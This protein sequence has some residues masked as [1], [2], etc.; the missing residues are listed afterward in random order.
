MYLDV[1]KIEAA[2]YYRDVMAF[3]FQPP[4]AQTDKIE[5]CDESEQLF[6]FGYHCKLF[7]DDDKA[8][9]IDAGEYLLPWMGN[10][11]IKI[12]RSVE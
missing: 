4:T 2:R 6:V 3:L 5:D 9:S 12:D 8:L 1:I 7:R 10:E 11:N